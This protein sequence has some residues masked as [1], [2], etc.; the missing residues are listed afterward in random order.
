MKRLYPSESATFR[1]AGVR[2]N[3]TAYDGGAFFYRAPTVEAVVIPLENGTLAKGW[4][5]ETWTADENVLNH[6]TVDG[7]GNVLDVE[8][9]T[10]SDSYNVFAEDPLK[11]AQTVVSGPGAGNAQSPAGWLGTAAQ[12]TINIS[13]NNVSAYLDA[14]ANNAPDSAGLQ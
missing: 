3:T 2:G 14:D 13:G 10:A 4:L 12:A 8:L 9:R 5:V 7:N 11:G 1:P 6:T